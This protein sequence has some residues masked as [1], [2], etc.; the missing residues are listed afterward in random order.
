MKVSIKLVIWM[1]QTKIWS[2]NQNDIWRF[3]FVLTTKSYVRCDSLESQ[4]KPKP[5]RLS[6]WSY[7]LL[8]LLR[9][10]LP[11]ILIQ[12]L[13]WA[14]SCTLASSPDS[15]WKVH[16]WQVRRIWWP[17]FVFLDKNDFPEYRPQEIQ[18][19]LVAPSCWYQYFFTVATT[20]AAG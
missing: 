6:S 15:K 1:L 13:H 20:L 4:R 18:T 2:E 12:Q 5:F 8:N 11:L 7:L 16:G 3:M 19:W 10:L 9:T 17:I 14:V